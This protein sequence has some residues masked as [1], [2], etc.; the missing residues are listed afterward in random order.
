MSTETPLFSSA[1]AGLWQS[2]ELTLKPNE[3]F[4]P[5]GGHSVSPRY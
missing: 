4:C 3:A 2:L 5:D 1:A